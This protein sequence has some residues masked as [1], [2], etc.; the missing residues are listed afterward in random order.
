MNDL[1]EARVRDA[2]VLCKSRLR[3]AQRL[4]KLSQEDAA[5]MSRSPMGRDR[6]RA[7]HHQ[8]LIMIIDDLDVDRSRFRPAEADA[9]PVVDSDRRLSGAIAVQGLEP[10]SWRDAQLIQAHRCVQQS[11]LVCGLLTKRS[12]DDSA[13]RLRSDAVVEIPRSAIREV[14]TLFYH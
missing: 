4:E 11:E 10:I 3:D 13:R 9:V 2:D 8:L 7:I 1:G 5:G 12:R 6:K 14:H